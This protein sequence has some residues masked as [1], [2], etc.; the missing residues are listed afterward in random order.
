MRL[1]AVQER[2]AGPRHARPTCAARACRTTVG[3]PARRAG[4]PAPGTRGRTA[5]HAAQHS[6]RTERQLGALVVLSAVQY[7]NQSLREP[8]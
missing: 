5:M 1:P 8:A 6:S 3:P 2:S 4:P 7:A